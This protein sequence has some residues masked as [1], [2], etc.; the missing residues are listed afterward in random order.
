MKKP[1]NSKFLTMQKRIVEQFKE[2]GMMR[3][4]SLRW[5]VKAGVNSEDI[6][7]IMLEVYPPD[8]DKADYL[9]RY[10]MTIDE[11]FEKTDNGKKN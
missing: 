9:Y 6:R 1:R 4:H 7:D 10:P 8:I 5:L 2:Q 11:A 3:T